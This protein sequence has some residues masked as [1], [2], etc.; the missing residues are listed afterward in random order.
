MWKEEVS[1]TNQKIADALA[2]P[3]NYENLFQDFKLTLQAE[4]VCSQSVVPIHMSPS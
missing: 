4:K 3:E 1:K 2:D